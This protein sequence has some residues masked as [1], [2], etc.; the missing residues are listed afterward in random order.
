LIGTQRVTIAVENRP[1]AIFRRTE[2][3]LAWLRNPP[4]PNRTR[5]PNSPMGRAFRDRDSDELQQPGL[6]QNWHRS[7]R[8]EI[9]VC[10]LGCTREGCVMSRNLASTDSFEDSFVCPC[11]GSRYDLAGRA[12]SGPAPHNLRVP[13]YRF[14]D[15][16]TIEFGAN[17]V[18]GVGGKT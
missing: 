7:L 11:C 15:A 16:T 17:D 13:P 5:D 10:D 2:D 6:A 14:I 4:M 18:V 3:Q 1:I 9:M 8:P 12:F